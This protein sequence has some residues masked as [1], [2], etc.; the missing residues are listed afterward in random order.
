MS[1][2]RHGSVLG[3]ALFSVYDVDIS[4]LTDH[5]VFSTIY[6]EDTAIV[7]TLRNTMIVAQLAQVLLH[8]IEGFFG[9]C[10]LTINSRKS[11]AIAFSWRL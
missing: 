5:R 2:V 10:D 4:K 11:Q 7:A 9:A 3:P 8:R 1:E 6:A